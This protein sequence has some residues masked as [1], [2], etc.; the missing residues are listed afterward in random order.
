MEDTLSLIKLNKSV[1][2]RMHSTILNSSILSND[3]KINELMSLCELK[4]GQKWNLIYKASQDGFKSSDFHS[5][6]DDKTN[7]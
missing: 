6:C 1:L 3:K 2:S 7:N 5:K 4:F